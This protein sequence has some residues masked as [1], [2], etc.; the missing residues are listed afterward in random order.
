M[1]RSEALK[2]GYVY[3]CAKCHNVIK[4]LPVTRKCVK[5]DHDV[6][7]NLEDDSLVNSR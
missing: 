4:E 5:C 7:A 2:N 6:F 1:I 3:Y